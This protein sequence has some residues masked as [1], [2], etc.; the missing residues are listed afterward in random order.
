[1]KNSLCLGVLAVTCL[2]LGAANAQSPAMLPPVQT[3]P[4]MGSP[5]ATPSEPQRGSSAKDA[6]ISPGGLNEYL[7]YPRPAGCCGLGCDGLIGTE[8]Y[9][10]SGVSINLGNTG[11]F[12]RVFD[13]GFMVQGGVR[14]VFFQPTPN[15]GWTVDVGLSTV[16]YDANRDEKAIIR[17]FASRRT[18]PVTQQTTTTIIPEFPVTPSS[19]NQTGVHLMLGQ[20]Y[21][22]QGDAD[23]ADGNWKWR[24]GWDAGGEWSSSKLVLKEI[25]HKTDVIGGALFSV[26]S[27]IEI[28]YGHC[29]F[30][31]GFRV[32]YSYTWSDILQAHNDTDLMALNLL[33]TTGVRY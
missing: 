5:A 17:N 25:R 19:L 6:P 30:Q 13:P 32:E 20:E 26:H 10:R 31:A 1:M 18:N 4:T 14:S 8:S 2:G 27:D 21:Y 9:V 23:P 3:I 29:I 28:P 24:A 15:M 22:F 7:A 12:G 33:F 11:L 16:W